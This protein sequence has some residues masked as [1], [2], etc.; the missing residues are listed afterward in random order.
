MTKIAFWRTVGDAYRFLFGDLA[1]F[2]VLS[3]A[4]LIVI[5]VTAIV[6]DALFLVSSVLAYLALIIGAVV[7]YFG[8]IFAFAVD[9][10]RAILRGGTPQMALH[11]GRREWRFFGYSALIGLI[12]MGILVAGGIAYFAL[13]NGRTG[14]RGIA[15]VLLPAV[16]VVAWG[17]LARL[18]LALPAVAV[19]EPGGQLRAAWRR[20]KGN[21]IRL[22]F[23]PFVC[24]IPGII[25]QAAMQ[26]VL[27]PPVWQAAALRTTQHARPTEGQLIVSLCYVVLYFVQTALAIGFL[28]FSY[29][30]VTGGSGP[31]A[32][33]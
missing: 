27:G 13:A 18:S 30:Q 25:L 29:R 6:A 16:L 21:T 33:P 23:G 19:D 5:V 9:W 20:A 3:G 22:F 31:P 1:R 4:W 24:A 17:I 28:S 14:A 7:F 11:F 2:F 10:H 12:F 15:A 8:G 26:A 32:R